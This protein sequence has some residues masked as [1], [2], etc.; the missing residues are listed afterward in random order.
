MYDNLNKDEAL[1]LAVD[2]EIR[3]TKR[4]GWRG[5]RI[6]EREVQNAIKKHISDPDKVA[7]IFE[8]VKN[9]NEY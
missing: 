2:A 5:N 8:I 9:Q 6:K 4:D 1:A 3:K 7:E